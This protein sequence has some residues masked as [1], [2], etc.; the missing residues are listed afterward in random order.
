MNS[1][2]NYYPYLDGLRAISALYVVLTHMVAEFGFHDLYNRYSTVKKYSILFFSNGILA[3]DFF[4]VV[5]GFCLTIPMINSNSFTMRGG[6][7]AFYLK[8]LKRIYLPYVCAIIFSVILIIT[9]VGNK[10]GTHWDLSIPVTKDDL[11]K[12]LLLIQDIF[13]SSCYKINHAFWSISIECR[14]YLFFPLMLW[15]WRKYGP[16]ITLFSAILISLI[17]FIVTWELNKYNNDISLGLEGVNPYLILFVLG[18]IGCEISFGNRSKFIL[19]RNKL[20]WG[21]LILF[22][23]I[24]ILVIQRLLLHSHWHA[25]ELIDILMGCCSICI[26]VAVSIK[27][28]YLDKIFSFRPLAFVGSFAYSIYLIHAP[29]LQF[30]WQVIN[31]YHLDEYIGFCLMASLGMLFVLAISYLFYI[32]FE[33]PFMNHKKPI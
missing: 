24:L 6:A 32:A 33:R 4:I 31:P 22:F 15:I 26:L 5:S 8:R 17:L 19:L 10:T 3:V 2:K 11:I 7:L 12:H 29:L 27:Q 28:F 1:T 30:I 18:M 21:A 16:I 9:V 20:P 25:I 23:G 14:I 13:Y